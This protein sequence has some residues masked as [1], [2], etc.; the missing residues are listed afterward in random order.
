ME[1]DELLQCYNALL[2]E[3]EELLI[4]NERLRNSIKTELTE[5]ESNQ[6]NTIVSEAEE[7]ASKNPIFISQENLMSPSEKIQLFMS[8]FH[9]RE[10][11]YPKRWQNQKGVSGYSPVCNNEWREAVCMKPK[12][13]CSNCNAQ[14]F[15]EVNEAVIEGHLKGKSVIGVYPLLKDDTTWFLAIDF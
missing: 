13:T 6:V 3:R 4:E 10:D 12:I 1:Y 8:L 9:G 7:Q 5:N 11:V 14:S 2:L 15:A